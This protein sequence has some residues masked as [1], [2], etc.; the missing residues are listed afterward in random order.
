MITSVLK[1]LDLPGGFEVAVVLMSSAKTM[2]IP[3]KKVLE[4]SGSNS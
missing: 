2:A 1:N 4:F 3:L